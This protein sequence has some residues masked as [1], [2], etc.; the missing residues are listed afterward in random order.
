MVFPNLAQG[1]F[2]LALPPVP[3]AT[4]AK[5]VNALGQV[6]ST[7][8]LKLLASGATVEYATSNLSPGLYT[9][10]V[11]AGEAAARLAVQ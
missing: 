6:V 4:T 1:H 8:T 9:L 3:E 5:L 11:R 7:R 10:R 2:T